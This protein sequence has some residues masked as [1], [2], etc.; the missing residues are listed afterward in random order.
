MRRDECGSGPQ[1]EDTMQYMHAW[2][3]TQMHS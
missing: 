2:A 3:Q 1:E